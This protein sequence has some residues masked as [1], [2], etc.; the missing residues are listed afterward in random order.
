MARSSSNGLGSP[1]PTLPRSVRQRAANLS[2]GEI[3]VFD[4]GPS[5]QA[6]PIPASRIHRNTGLL[7]ENPALYTA[8]DSLATDNGRNERRLCTEDLESEAVSSASEDIPNPHPFS[9][10]ERRRNVMIS[11]GPELA[12]FGT[13]PGR[14]LRD[15]R[16]ASSDDVQSLGHGYGY[17]YGY[18]MQDNH[19]HFS[20]ESNSHVMAR[21]VPHSPRSPPAPLRRVLYPL[22]YYGVVGPEHSNLRNVEQANNPTSGNSSADPRYWNEENQQSDAFEKRWD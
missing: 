7:R 18:S 15:S 13:R 17:G 14:Q 22:I 3:S 5:L 21:S 4:L 1:G 10:C 20:D 16:V 9:Q 12:N 19:L 11:R 2:E 8:L 6:T